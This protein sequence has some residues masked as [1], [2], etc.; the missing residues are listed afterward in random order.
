MKPV[1]YMERDVPLER[2]AEAPGRRIDHAADD[3]SMYLRFTI[4]K[5]GKEKKRWIEAG[6]INEPGRK[7]RLSKETVAWAGCEPVDGAA[8]V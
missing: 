7:W 6:I 3:G 4:K 5:Q 2:D 1:L 8:Y